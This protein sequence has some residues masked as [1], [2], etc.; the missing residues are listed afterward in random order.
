[1]RNKHEFEKQFDDWKK[2]GYRDNKLSPMQETEVKRAFMGGVFEG[3]NFLI[4]HMENP[5]IETEIHNAYKFLKAFHE[6][7]CKLNGSSPINNR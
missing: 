6:N 5:N 7:E 3:L 1:M 4:N 2:A